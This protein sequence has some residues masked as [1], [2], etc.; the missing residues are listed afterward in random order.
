[1]GSE[2]QQGVNLSILKN[3]IMIVEDDG[4]IRESLRMILEMDGYE[5]LEAENGKDALSLLQ[6]GRLPGLIFL[7]LMMPIMDGVQFYQALRNA[8]E[9]DPI[10]AVILSASGN[11]KEKIAGMGDPLPP[12]LKKP[13]DL[14]KILEVTQKY[15]PIG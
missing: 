7:D 9:W 6:A 10:I 4:P 12:V 14:D 13:V 5:V 1:V 11:L 15:C 2:A 3:T 8:P